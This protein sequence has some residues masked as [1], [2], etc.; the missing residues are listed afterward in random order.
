MDSLNQITPHGDIEDRALDIGDHDAFTGVAEDAGV[1]LQ[2]FLD[3]LARADVSLHIVTV[4][5]VQIKDGVA[6]AA[7]TLADGH[8]FVTARPPLSRHCEEQSDAAI[9]MTNQA[10]RNDEEE[11]AASS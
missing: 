1:E 6:D 8:P 7:E 4:N 5:D 10:T 3:L 2:F 9:E 11:R